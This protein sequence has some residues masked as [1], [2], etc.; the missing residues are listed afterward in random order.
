MLQDNYPEEYQIGE[1][2]FFGKRFSITSDVLIP[3]LET[4]WL[5]HRARE[6]LRRENIRTLVDIWTGSGIIGIS[7]ADLFEEV[8]LL[9]ISNEALEVAKKNFKFH[10]PSRKWTFIESNLLELYISDNPEMVLFTANLPYIK[11]W[12]WRNMSLDTRY[13]PE[14]ALFGWEVTGFEL[15]EKLFRQFHERRIQ[16]ILLIEFWFDQ[17]DIVEEVLKEYWWKYDFFPDY[18]GIER[19]CEIRMQ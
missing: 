2:I 17:R 3:R 16:G 13:E 18:A 12:D 14:L 4:E 5:V 8:V 11:A 19:F 9:D 10:L 7:C 6:I 1:V 15:Y